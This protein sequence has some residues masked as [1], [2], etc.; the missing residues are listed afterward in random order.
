MALVPGTYPSADQSQQRHLA[1]QVESEKLSSDQ[2]ECTRIVKIQR[3]KGERA[4]VREGPGRDESPGSRAGSRR[5][6]VPDRRTQGIRSVDPGA[7][8][9]H[10]PGRGFRHSSLTRPSHQLGHLCN[11]HVHNP[12]PIRTHSRSCHKGRAHLVACC[13]LYPYVHSGDSVGWRC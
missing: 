9:D 8:P 12:P 3:V 11:P 13:P 10:A 5:R 6:P 7:A 2:N 4:Q 1:A